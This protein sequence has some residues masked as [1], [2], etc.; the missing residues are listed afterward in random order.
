MRKLAETKSSKVSIGF[1]VTEEEMRD[2]QRDRGIDYWIRIWP[3]IPFRRIAGIE[4]S[5]RLLLLT[6]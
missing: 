2:E 6:A 1:F 4:L 3:A 5:F